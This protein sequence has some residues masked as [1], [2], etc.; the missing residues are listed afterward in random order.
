MLEKYENQF[1]LANIVLEGL[2][3]WVHGREFPEA[4]DYWDGNW[5]NVTIY[6]GTHNA[7][8]WTSGP[9]MHLPGLA[10][11]LEACERM[12]QTLS[13][14][15]SL[16]YIEPALAVK[17]QIDKQ[18]HIVSTVEITPDFIAQEHIFRF[19]VDQSYLP[20][21]IRGCQDVLTTFPVR[22]LPDTE[23]I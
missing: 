13:G 2:H 23:Q 6:Y 22:G 9:V 19:E 8:V 17:L 15:A 14:E 4:H 18:G 5:L 16:T 20:G 10:R 12:Y 21:L 1:G 11:W 7:Q 3:I